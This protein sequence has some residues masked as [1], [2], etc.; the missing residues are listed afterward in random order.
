MSYC[1]RMTFCLLVYRAASKHAE[2]RKVLLEQPKMQSWRYVN[3]YST[4]IN[5]SSSQT[6][7]AARPNHHKL[8]P[9]EDMP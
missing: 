8:Y 3:Y 1:H 4:L 2:G 7:L 5:S 9:K 6:G